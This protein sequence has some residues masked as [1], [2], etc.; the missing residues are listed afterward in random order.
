MSLEG[1]E[2]YDDQTLFA[3]YMHHRLRSGDGNANETLE[4][5]VFLD[6]VGQVTGARI[7]DLGCGDASFGREALQAGAAGYTGLEGSRNMA[8]AARAT[9]EGTT[10]QV[11]ETPIQDWEFQSAAFDL[12]I[13][14]LALHYVQDYDLLCKRVFSALAAGGRFI[15]SVEH[16]VMT[17]SASAEQPAGLHQA[18]IVDDYFSTG[19]RVKGWLGG[20]VVIY[21]RTV[22]DYF[23]GLQRAG[24]VVEHLRESRPRREFFTN[25]ETYARRLRIPLLLFLAARKADH[26]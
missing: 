24:F 17:S 2:F 18:R 22:E 14:R 8:Q 23:T 26:P 11:V 4:R 9:L 25:A 20:Q 19:S 1:P 10:G 7:L 3:T 16:P 12:I 21:H 5:P 15:F 13:S 6:L